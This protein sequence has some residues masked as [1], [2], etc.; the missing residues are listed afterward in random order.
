M[1]DHNTAIGEKFKELEKELL[2]ENKKELAGFR[3]DMNKDKSDGFA[4]TLGYV[5]DIRLSSR[6]VELAIR[7]AL[8]QFNQATQGRGTYQPYALD[9]L[10][11]VLTIGAQDGKCIPEE[12]QSE[13]QTILERQDTKGEAR[14]IRLK[15]KLTQIGGVERYKD[16]LRQALTGI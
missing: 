8:E 15:E 12:L 14:G 16:E 4:Y 1:K 7:A 11:D 6:E 5:A 3:Q 2:A 9:K 13:V 10:T